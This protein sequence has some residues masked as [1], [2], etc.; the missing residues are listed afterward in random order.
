M[1]AALCDHHSPLDQPIVLLYVAVG[2]S[3]RTT[4]NINPTAFRR[5]MH[6]TRSCRLRRNN[7]GRSEC[8]LLLQSVRYVLALA[9]LCGSDNDINI[10]ASGLSLQLQ[11]ALL[12]R[13]GQCRDAEHN[14]R[15]VARRKGPM[16]PPTVAGV[17]PAPTAILFNLC[18]RLG[19]LPCHHR[20]RR[21]H[22]SVKT[23][24]LPPGQMVQRA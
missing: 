15:Q 11:V 10:A 17:G 6:F 16:A 22:Y 3:G 19:R 2:E 7:G 23:H 4:L 12:L 14:D 5:T 1:L 24:R 21:H 9:E 20:W 8:A 18:L 13:C